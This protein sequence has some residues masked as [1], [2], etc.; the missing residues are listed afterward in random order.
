RTT[1]ALK[2]AIMHGAVLRVRPKLMTFFSILA[3]LI[4]IMYSHGTG[5]EIMK[6]IAAPMLGGMISSVVLTLFIIPTAYFVIKNA[7]I[8]KH[9]Y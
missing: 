5:S 7:R 1:T 8:R 6:S 9:E 4:P 2:E 3:S